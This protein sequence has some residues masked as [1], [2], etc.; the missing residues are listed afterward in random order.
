MFFIAAFTSGVQVSLAG[1]S[2]FLLW[3]G[4]RKGA[5]KT[6]QNAAIAQIQVD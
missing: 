1:S 2:W 5:L 6:T 4:E 3:L